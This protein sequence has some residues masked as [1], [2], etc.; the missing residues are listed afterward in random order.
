MNQP[1]DLSFLRLV[2]V[3]AEEFSKDPSTQ[4]GALIIDKYNRQISAGYNGFPRGIEDTPERLNNRDIKYDLTL[5]AEHNAILFAQRSLFDCT[6]Y[7]WPFQPCVRCACIIIQVGIRRVVCPHP[8]TELLDR[9][10]YSLLQAQ[11]LFAE[12]GIQLD[13][14]QTEDIGPKASR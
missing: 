6:L 1:K 13:E 12:A 10:G 2:Q 9:W 7:T 14:Y 5:H 8:S 4:V 11:K 3:N